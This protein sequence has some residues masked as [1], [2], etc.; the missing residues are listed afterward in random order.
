MAVLGLAAIEIIAVL[1]PFHNGATAMRATPDIEQS[2]PFKLDLRLL[3]TRL[4][5]TCPKPARCE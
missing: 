5:A 3:A 1:G 4:P 2:P